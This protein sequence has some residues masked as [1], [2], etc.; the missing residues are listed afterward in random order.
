VLVRSGSGER[1]R[2][3]FLG[4]ALSHELVSWAAK[5]SGV[6]AVRFQIR[7]LRGGKR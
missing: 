3:Y 5:C 2:T 1:S 4:F 7:G 6:E